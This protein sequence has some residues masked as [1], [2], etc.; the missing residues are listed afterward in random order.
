MGVSGVWNRQPVC[1]KAS[2][3]RRPGGRTNDEAPTTKEIRSP[4]DEFA[5]EFNLRHWLYIRHSCLVIRHSE[6]QD[7]RPD[8]Q[9]RT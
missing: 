7:T 6:P 3:L 8:Q 9:I 5:V 1:D 4:N 2:G